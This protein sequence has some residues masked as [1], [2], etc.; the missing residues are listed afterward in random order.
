MESF[1][2]NIRIQFHAANYVNKFV[3]FNG[4]KG[5]VSEHL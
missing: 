5:M 2:C 1:I 3:P 4:N